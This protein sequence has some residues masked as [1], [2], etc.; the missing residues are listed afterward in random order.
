MSTFSRKQGR[1]G[2]VHPAQKETPL[3]HGHQGDKQT[4]C[5]DFADNAAE[6][7]PI[8]PIF[9]LA[10]WFVQDANIKP[11]RTDRKQKSAWKRRVA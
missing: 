8:K 2:P 4:F 11:S 6:N 10:S 1:L 9:N 3:H 5:K 7:K